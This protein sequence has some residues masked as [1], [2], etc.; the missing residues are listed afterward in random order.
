MLDLLEGYLDKIAAAATQTVAKLG[1]LSELAASLAIPVDTVARQK[2]EIKRLYKKINAMKK[3]GTQASS[4]G[5]MKGGGLVGKVCSYCAA[6][7]RTTLHK[8][9]LC[10]FD[11]KK[12]T[13]R[14]EW[15]Q[16]LME[17]K[18]VAY[19][20][21]EW[22][23]GTAQTVVHRYPLKQTLLYEYILRYSPTLSYIPTPYAP[24]IPPK[25]GTSILDSG[26][27]HL[28]ITP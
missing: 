13:D 24:Q 9:N 15:A 4:I 6:V 28:Y 20:D 27:T 23:W 25:Q 19:K 1:P 14:R 11:P 26:A 22:R 16:K 3:R 7:G 2:H 5:A 12:M 8:N 10:Y 17:E 18:G 21:E